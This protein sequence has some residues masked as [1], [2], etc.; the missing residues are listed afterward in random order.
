MSLRL[1]GIHAAVP[2]KKPIRHASHSRTVSD[3]LIVRLTLPD[4]AVGHGEGVP[5]PY[6]TGETIETAFEALKSADLRPLADLP[7]TFEEAVERIA[8]WTLPSLVADPR[9]CFG[10][11]ARCALELAYLDAVGRRWGRSFSDAIAHLARGRPFLRPA[12]APVRYSGAITAEAP[13]KEVVSALKMRL[14]GFHQIKVKVGL[15]ERDDA[16]RLRRIRRIVGAKRDLRLDA[17]EAWP[18]EG[19]VERIE[20]LLRFHPSALEQPVPHAEVAGLA[21]A[22]ERIGVPIMLDESLCGLPDARRA[23]DLGLADILNVRIS[24]CGGLAP[25]LRIIELAF[26]HNIKLQL[27]CHPGETGLLSAAG[28]HLASRID[29]FRYVEGS[30]DRHVLLE[31]PTEPDITFRYGGRARPIEGPGLGV[32]VRPDRLERIAQTRIEVSCD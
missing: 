13:V 5:R 9:G 27:G 3:N 10:N 28:R 7:A 12:P 32:A 4:G 1:E 2:L 16:E 21:A 24:K 25:S 15:A 23:I 30:Y 11:A 22:R 31:N 6:V 17:N 26:E 18:V 20:P 8:A 19:L 29:G 14:Y